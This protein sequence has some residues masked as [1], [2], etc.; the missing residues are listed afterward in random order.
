MYNGLF[1]SLNVELSSGLIVKAVSYTRIW[2]HTMKRQILPSIIIILLITTNTIWWKDKPSIYYHSFDCYKY[3]IPPRERP[4]PNQRLLFRSI[5]LPR[6][7]LDRSDHSI[8]NSHR[9]KMII[10]RIL[11]INFFA[12]MSVSSYA[13]PFPSSLDGREGRLQ[14]RKETQML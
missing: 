11:H 10:H 14:Q 4:Y 7:S 2:A 9:N 1:S 3:Q 13:Q 12:S 6:M 8:L 5:F